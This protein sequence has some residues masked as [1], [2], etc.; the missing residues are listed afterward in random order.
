MR[1][2]LDRRHVSQPSTHELF[3][4][5][6]ASRA[7]APIPGAWDAIPLG[8]LPTGACGT[9]TFAACEG[10]WSGCTGSGEPLGVESVDMSAW[11]VNERDRK[12]VC[13][14]NRRVRWSSRGSQ[15]VVGSEVRVTAFAPSF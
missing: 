12:R 15:T 6:L 4:I 3:A 9:T 13:R 8:I 5:F 2:E 11:V 14:R 10:L 1:R 7:R